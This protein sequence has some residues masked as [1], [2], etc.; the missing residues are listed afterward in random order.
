MERQ[1][2]PAG[3]PMLAGSLLKDEMTAAPAAGAAGRG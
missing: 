1:A 2:I 3:W